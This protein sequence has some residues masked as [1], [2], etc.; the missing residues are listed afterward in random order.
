MYVYSG[1]RKCMA[2]PRRS[3]SRINSGTSNEERSGGRA[4]SGAAVWVAYA[5][6]I[7]AP[8]GGSC[9]VTIGAVCELALQICQPSEPN[10]MA[11]A[12]VLNLR[13]SFSVD[14]RVESRFSIA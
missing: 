1:S 4:S 5:T 9:R 8:G 2:V 14:F 11:N 13:Q 6:L 7:F 10:E 12:N 3:L